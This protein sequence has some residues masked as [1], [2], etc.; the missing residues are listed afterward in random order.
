MVRPVTAWLLGPFAWD[1]QGYP[2]GQ[3]QPTGADLSVSKG[4]RRVEPCPSRARRAPAGRSGGHSSQGDWQTRRCC[5]R[6]TLRADGSC[7]CRTTDL[8]DDRMLV[9]LLGQLVGVGQL[10]SHPEA[11]GSGPGKPA[12]GRTA[13]PPG[14]HAPGQGKGTPDRATPASTCGQLAQPTPPGAAGPPAQH[15]QGVEHAGADRSGPPRRSTMNP[16]M[17]CPRSVSLRGEDGGAASVLT[18]A[19][20][21]PGWVRLATREQPPE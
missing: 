7:R 19:G 1:E 21:A 13:A 17:R 9:Y 12:S 4:Q 3:T 10:D 8:E 18:G 2:P 5:D 14:A 16:R 11:S 20:A 6:P 15:G